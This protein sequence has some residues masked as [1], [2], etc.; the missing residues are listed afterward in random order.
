MHTNQVSKYQDILEQLRSVLFLICSPDGTIKYANPYACKIVGKDL[1]QTRLCDIFVDFCSEQSLRKLLHGQDKRHLLNVVTKEGLPQSF[2]FTCYPSDDDVIVIAER[3]GEDIERLRKELV[4]LN[5]EL[6][7]KT[8]ELIKKNMQLQALNALKNQFLGIAAHD[9]RTPIGAI[10][11]YTEFLLSEA[12]QRLEEEHISF[13]ATIKSLSEFMLSLLNSLLDMTAY[14]AG[15]IKLNITQTD[16]P[17]LV[18]ES[19][20]LLSVFAEVK[21]IKIKQNIDQGITFIQSDPL[22]I[23]Q[24]LDNLLNNAIKFSAKNSTISVYVKDEGRSVLIQVHDSGK[25]IAPD[26]LHLLFKPFSTTSTKGTHGE[27]STGLG[28]FIARRLVES[29][30]GRIWAENSP[31]GGATFSFS[32]PKNLS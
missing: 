30:R 27:K 29:L 18:Q 4:I 3:D 7:N 12:V 19:I 22:R 8:R 20:R 16:I 15:A 23:R 25:G 6:N 10:K 13:L 21:G 24:V 32:I 28:L 1:V 26:E 5:N 14:E 9:L 31:E 17:A 2:Y 11:S